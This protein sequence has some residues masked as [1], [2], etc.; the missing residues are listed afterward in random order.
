MEVYQM[1]VVSGTSILSIW[2]AL[3]N[4]LS[5]FGAFISDS[6]LGRFRVIATGSFSALLGMISLWLN[7][8]VPQ[9]TPSC[10]GLD[11][12]C[13]P[14]SLT[15]LVFLYTCFILLS[16][17]SGCIRPCS[18]AFGADQLKHHP[19]LSNERVI[20]R[21]I[22][23]CCV[24]YALFC[25]Y[26]CTLVASLRQSESLFT[27][28]V[29]VL[30]VAFKNRRIC[31]LPDGCYSHSEETDQDELTDNL[32]YQMNG[33]RWLLSL[34]NNHLNGILADEMRLGKTVQV[35]SLLYYLM[36]NKNDRGQGRS[37][38]EAGRGAR[39]PELFA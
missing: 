20:E 35:I 12:S 32:R 34:Y 36:E 5:I 16:I 24:N 30:V 37:F 9:L 28:L 23:N 22:R 1:E 8:V 26:V 19:S 18:I 14:R 39:P 27:G 2:S 10:D 38:Q 17:G 4:G 15:H 31:L 29:Q 6:Y 7:S 13:N 11:T 25:S 33:L 3:S 21:R